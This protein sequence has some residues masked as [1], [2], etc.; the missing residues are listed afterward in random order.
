MDI[1]NSFDKYLYNTLP[2]IY[3]S[4][5]AKIKPNPEPLR[6]FLQILNEGGFKPIISNVDRLRNLSNIDNANS[7][8]LSNIVRALGLEFPY[9][10]TDSERR[11]YI[12]IIPSLY[13]LKG[14][15]DSFN[16]LAR[17]IFSTKSKIDTKVAEY[18]EG[19]TPE[20]WRKIFLN[21]E[22]DGGLPDIQRKEE[23]FR[24]FVE[25]IRPVNRILVINLMLMYYTSY[26][27]QGRARDSSFETLKDHQGV[28]RFRYRLLVDG[29]DQN[30]KNSGIILGQNPNEFLYLNQGKIYGNQKLKELI[31]IIDD[32][33]VLD[34]IIVSPDKEVF[35]FGERVSDFFDNFFINATNLNRFSARLGYNSHRDV[36]ILNEGVNSYKGDIHDNYDSTLMS[37]LDS[38]IFSN[39][40]TS[41]DVVSSSKLNLVKPITELNKGMKLNSSFYLTHFTP[42]QTNFSY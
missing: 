13:K 36:I 42:L 18:V 19:M 3:R 8:D 31:K 12:K 1:N 2:P 29:V 17:E 27:L 33:K 9:N 41:S 10:M 35:N 15:E 4:E 5:D 11:K 20:E 39:K 14:A 6:R 28:D 40:V 22:I 34:S 23:N 32:S 21:I 16:Y 30:I 38:D 37:N 25:I 7:E 26:D 24:K